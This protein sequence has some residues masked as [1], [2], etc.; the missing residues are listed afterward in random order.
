MC[1]SELSLLGRGTC[2]SVSVIMYLYLAKWQWHIVS[3]VKS[4]FRTAEKFLISK[5]VQENLHDML[6]AEKYL[7]M[8][9]LTRLSL[10]K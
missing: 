5:D 9:F 10:Q 4:R 3:L 2:S 7:A 8:V 1:L 6:S